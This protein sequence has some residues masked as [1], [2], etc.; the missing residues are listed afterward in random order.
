MSSTSEHT[1]EKREIDEPHIIQLLSEWLIFF[2]A[3]D[4]QLN[5]HESKLF[6][7]QE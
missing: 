7:T 6:D 4:I 1:R 2:S 3:L 5:K